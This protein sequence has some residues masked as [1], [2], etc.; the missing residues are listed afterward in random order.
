MISLPDVS[1]IMG[2]GGQ[3]ENYSNNSTLSSFQTPKNK[4]NKEEA[5]EPESDSF[6]LDMVELGI[7]EIR[8]DVKK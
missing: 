8:L 5:Y 4:N 6:C 7:G 3:A 2:N 1:S